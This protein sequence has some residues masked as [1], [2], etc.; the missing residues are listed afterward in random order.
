MLPRLLKKTV[1]NNRKSR[2]RRSAI[3]SFEFLEP[4]DVPAT[5]VPTSRAAGFAGWD[6]PLL[7]AGPAGYTPA[8]IRHAYAFDQISLNGV[9]GD[10]SGQTIAI[11]DA[12]DDPSIGADLHQFDLAFGLPD[13]VLMKVN[14]SGGAAL[15]AASATW[16]PEISLDVEWAHAIAP[17]ANILLVEA[18]SNS[19]ADLF[20]AVATAAGHPGVSVVSMSW[21]SG[22]FSSEGASDATFTTPVGHAG[23]TFVASAG[24]SGAPADYPAASPNVLAVG[25]TELGLSATGGWTG[26]TAWTDGGGGPS[27][28]ETLPSYQQGVVP[29]GTTSRSTPDVAY[30]A[31]PNTGFAI[32]DSFNFSSYTPWAVYGG[33]SAGAPQWAALV[34]IADQGRAL[35]GQGSLDGRSQTLPALYQ[36]PAGDFHDITTGT[37]AGTPNYSAGTGYDL[38][39]GRGTPIANLVVSGL[40]NYG[41]TPATSQNWL[42][43]GGQ[44]SALAGGSN[45]DGSQQVFTIGLDGALWVRTLSAGGTWGGWTSLGGPAHGLAITGNVYGFQDAFVIGA[46]GAVWMR[47]ETA[48]GQWSAWAS[49]GGSVKSLTAGNNADGSE[50]VFGLD[51]AGALWVRTQTAFGQWSGWVNLGGT[52]ESVTVARN[53][54][55]LLDAFMIGSSGAVWSRTQISPGRWSP[56]GSLGGSLKS[57]TTGSN[58][59]GSQEVFGLDANGALWVRTLTVTGQW[60]GWINLGGTGDSVTVARNRYGLLDAF[61]IGS[62]GTVWSRTQTAFGQWSAWTSLGGSAASLAATSD[63]LG[64]LT[65]FINGGNNSVSSRSQ[66]LAGAWN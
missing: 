32:Y 17:G 37:S 20:S 66:T 59:D 23:V 54:Y 65:L 50:Q 15:P 26:E 4:R 8:Q 7:S 13:P 58:A 53:R 21:G 45:T 56:W 41:Y 61:V 2:F 57:L 19:N 46:D 43:L 35:V 30:N 52:G 31:D 27:I 28:Y 51:S 40:V 38:V 10:G 29:F 34:A 12:Y 1:R 44:G 39:T 47:S 16:A 9:A 24:D 42:S 14:Q 36:L 18:N 25:G 63:W 60:S 3:L 5:F 64:Q 11:V 6:A 62:D 49:L 55:G 48:A 22:E 33:T